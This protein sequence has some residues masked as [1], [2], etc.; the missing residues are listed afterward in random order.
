A[1]VLVFGDSRADYAQCLVDLARNSRRQQAR[2]GMQTMLTHDE[3]KARVNRIL[4][5]KT[6][7]IRLTKKQF[8]LRAVTLTLFSGVLLTGV[9]RAPL[10]S[11]QEQV[12]PERGSVLPV[13]VVQPKYPTIA[14]EQ[15][16]EGHVRVRFTVTEQGAV[17]DLEI[18]EDVP[19]GIFNRS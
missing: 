8:T 7:K 2:L 3:L 15:A 13:H 17:E 9:G 1:S 5:D 14:A 18:V 6:M 16:I 11:A 19:P 12:A 10:I 4:E